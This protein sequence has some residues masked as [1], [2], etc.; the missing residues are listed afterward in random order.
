[1]SFSYTAS[2]GL[3]TNNGA[4][5]TST[6]GPYEV[7]EGY[8]FNYPLNKLVNVY[9]DSPEALQR[10]KRIKRILYGNGPR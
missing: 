2:G 7:V 5:A 10:L 3:S 8:Q 9:L 6:T 1:M 4:I